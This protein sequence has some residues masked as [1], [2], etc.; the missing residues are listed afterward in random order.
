MDIEEM[1][2]IMAEDPCDSLRDKKEL[3]VTDEDVNYFVDKVQRLVERNASEAALAQPRKQLEVIKEIAKI[4]KESEPKVDVT[5]QT[6]MK[7]MEEYMKNITSSCPDTMTP[8]LGHLFRNITERAIDMQAAKHFV[9]IQPMTGPIGL[10]YSLQYNTEI[11]TNE[12][13]PPNISL[14]VVSQAIEASSRKLGALIALEPSQD[15]SDSELPATGTEIAQEVYE[16]IKSDISALA[17]KETFNTK[18][19]ID[20][21][22]EISQHEINILEICINKCANDIA[23]R[24]RRGAGNFIII[25]PTIAKI[26]KHS[27]NFVAAASDEYDYGY[28]TYLGTLNNIIKIYCDINIKHDKVLMGYKGSTETDAGYVY[29]P[30]IPVLSGGIV[31]DPLTFQPIMRF[32]TRYGKYVNQKLLEENTTEDG[33]STTITREPCNYYVEITF[34]NLPKLNEI[35]LKK[36]ETKETDEMENITD[37]SVD[38]LSD[39]FESAMEIVD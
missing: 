31:V 7:N 4:Q 37:T 35:K 2:K 24:T 22:S 20:P 34:D 18:K 3:I 9:S 38:V 25:S 10:V 15:F 26:L 11:T 28:V 23:R 29:A 17:Y 13:A 21:L 27:D 12:E 30:Y 6:L 32:Y 33:S 8:Q 19:I 1:K 5:K 16:E 39:S 14:V 36:N